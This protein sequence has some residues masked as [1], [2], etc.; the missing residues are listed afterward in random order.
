MSAEKANHV[1]ALITT[2]CD[3]K[4]HSRHRALTEMGKTDTNLIPGPLLQLTTG[5]IRI[6]PRSV[7][8]R[9]PV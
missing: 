6:D 2:S 8:N 5:T 7:R 1:V 4:L 9:R 3:G